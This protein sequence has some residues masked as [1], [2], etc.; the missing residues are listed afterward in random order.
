GGGVHGQLMLNDFGMRNGKWEIPANKIHGALKFSSTEIATDGLD[1]EVLGK[2]FHIGGTQRF[3]QGGS[4]DVRLQAVVPLAKLASF[5]PTLPLEKFTSGELPVSVEI[6]LASESEKPTGS[7]ELDSDL[8]G[9]QIGAPFP[10]G[11]AAPDKIASH[12]HTEFQ[13]GAV[14]RVQARLKR[15]SGDSASWN[16]DYRG[17]EKPR[18]SASGELAHASAPEW[19]DFIDQVKKAR[20]E[21]QKNNEDEKPGPDPVLDA[22]LKIALFEAMGV[23][24]HET[25]LRTQAEGERWS[26]KIFAKEVAGEIEYLR[27]KP[28]PAMN[29]R[30][31]YL[32]LA[33]LPGSAAESGGGAAKLNPK[34]LP[35]LQLRCERLELAGEKLGAVQAKL[36]Q[37]GTALQLD[38]FSLK[39]QQFE[40][41]T[42]EGETLYQPAVKTSVTGRVMV[43]GYERK[44][45]ELKIFSSVAL[46]RGRVAFDV[47]WPGGP[48]DFSLKALSGDFRGRVQ[49]GTLLDMKTSFDQKLNLMSFNLTDMADRTLRF[50]NLAFDLSSD[51]GRVHTKWAKT[52]FGPTFLKLIGKTDT[53]E[54]MLDMRFLVTRV[55]AGDIQS[56][57]PDE[58]IPV[59]QEEILNDAAEHPDPDG[60]ALKYRVSGSWNDPKVE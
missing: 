22:A 27:S 1:A 19:T 36:T 58:P 43:H 49:K 29:A 21:L 50:R 25:D 59:T 31:D 38:E 47:S 11:K 18:I 9:L 56:I 33:K 15:I 57:D 3:A 35:S 5:A 44:F 7:V 40:I 52:Y 17:G 45:E 2:P 34:D 12:F 46:G 32:V 23:Q 6:K 42:D 8:L 54:G 10:F 53:I 60:S 37:K 28:F 39:N 24:W 48:E 16:L 20:K 30:L 4:S 26:A 14:S 13:S 41:I 55:I 51:Q